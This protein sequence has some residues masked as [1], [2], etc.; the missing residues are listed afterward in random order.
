MRYHCHIYYNDQT[1]ES[2]DALYL[3]LSSLKWKTLE[4]MPRKDFPTGPHPLPMVEAHFAE[5]DFHFLKDWLEK[6]RGVH[7]V[8]LHED[9]G[10]DRVDHTSG[11]LWLGEKQAIDFDYFIT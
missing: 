5:E 8:L 9:T 7:S 6:N 10:H 4:L 1:R 2:M 3:S 11:A